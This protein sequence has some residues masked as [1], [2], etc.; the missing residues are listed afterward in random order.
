MT[1]PPADA[2]KRSS[3]PFERAAVFQQ[4]QQQVDDSS[5]RSL[6]R[7]SGEFSSTFKTRLSTFEM[8]DPTA[9]EERKPVERSATP[10][11]VEATGFKNKLAAFQSVEATKSNSERRNSAPVNVAPESNEEQMNFKAKLAAFRQAEVPKPTPAAAP[12]PQARRQSLDVK[13]KPALEASGTNTPAEAAPV[14][15]VKPA[16]PARNPLL[17]RTEPIYANSAMQRDPV[18]APPAVPEPIASPRTHKPIASA[19]QSRPN[20][21]ESDCTEDEGIRSLS[22]HETQ[23]PTS[24]THSHSH[25]S[26][27]P[28]AFYPPEADPAP[29][30]VNKEL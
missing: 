20:N 25:Q 10:E 18:D 13:E 4:Q 9:P 7:R 3:S 16:L 5:L 30:P 14:K 29:Q 28:A 21:E 1:D 6:Q 2:V 22:P 15:Q 11:R 24:P 23:S 26:S 19:P 27:D 12:A 17:I 8:A